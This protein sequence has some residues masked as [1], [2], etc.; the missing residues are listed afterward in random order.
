MAA[1]C[2]H[3]LAIFPSEA[4]FW[5]HGAQNLPRIAAWERMARISCHCRMLGNAYRV[6]FAIAERSGAHR[7]RILPWQ[8]TWER[9]APMPRPCLC[10]ASRR[11]ASARTCLSPW[12]RNDERWRRGGSRRAAGNGVSVYRSASA[13][14]RSAAAAVA[15][16]GRCY[17][18]V[19]LCK[20]RDRPKVESVTIAPGCHQGFSVGRRSL[21]D[22]QS[23]V[24]WQ[25]PAGGQSYGSG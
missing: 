13:A 15:R 5:I 16:C 2:C 24:G 17:L 22:W 11:G 9:P 19:L 23:P 12:R 20:H 4:P 3:E 21:T 18:L 10:T 8:G 14:Y 6:H 7:A 1:I 25:P